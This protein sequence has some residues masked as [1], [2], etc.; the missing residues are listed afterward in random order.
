MEFYHT[1]KVI[2]TITRS[3][4]EKLFA[5]FLGILFLLFPLLS[6]FFLFLFLRRGLI[7]YPK[8]SQVPSAEIIGLGLSACFRI[9]DANFSSI[10]EF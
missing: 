1:Q 6:F 2:N 9:D 4:P 8:L 7:L 10:I 3:S 5:S